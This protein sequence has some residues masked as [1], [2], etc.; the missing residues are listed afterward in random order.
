M[1]YQAGIIT[2]DQVKD[3]H[4]DFQV[5]L[6][7]EPLGGPTAQNSRA[8]YFSFHKGATVQPSDSLQGVRTKVLTLIKKTIFGT[9]EST[10]NPQMSYLHLLNTRLMIRNIFLHEF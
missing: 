1:F 8:S 7:Q 9:K 10:V 2:T 3:L 4:S 5:W 6:M